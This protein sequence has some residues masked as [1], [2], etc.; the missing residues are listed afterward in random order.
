M[1]FRLIRF[2]IYNIS[3]GFKLKM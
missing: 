2:K 3:I 1:K